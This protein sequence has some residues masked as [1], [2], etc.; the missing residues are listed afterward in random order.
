MYDRRRGCIYPREN[1]VR[2]H[3]RSIILSRRR[4]NESSRK[5]VVPSPTSARVLPAIT[6]RARRRTRSVQV[7]SPDNAGGDCRRRTKT[8]ERSRRH[9]PTIIPSPSAADRHEFNRK[10]CRGNIII[11][12]R[13]CIQIRS[14]R[15]RTYTFYNCVLIFYRIR[16]HRGLIYD[17]TNIYI[18]RSAGLK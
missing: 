16:G 5:S 8:F 10:A 15:C 11:L 7:S 2:G 6:K 4:T 12:E 9:R 18:Y 14:R 1:T 3:A 13:T 17:R